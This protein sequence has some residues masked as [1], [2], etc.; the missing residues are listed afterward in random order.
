MQSNQT[1]AEAR[2]INVEPG[3]FLAA[4]HPG[5][6]YLRTFSDTGKGAGRNYQ[7]SAV[8]L[9]ATDFQAGLHLVNQRD[10]QGVFFVVNPGGHRD[11]AITRVAAHFVEADD[12][13]LEEQYANLQTFPLEPSIIVQTRKSLHGYWL[14]QPPESAVADQSQSL[15]SFSSIQKALAAVFKGDPVISNRSRV[16]R[17]PGFFHNK[18]EPVLVTCLKFDP[19]L[20]YTQTDIDLAIQSVTKSAPSPTPAAP[21]AAAKSAS[22]PTA[23][24]IPGFFPSADEVN[25]QRMIKSC[26]FL[27]HAKATAKTLSEPLWYAMITQLA[28]LAGGDAVIQELSRDHPGYSPAATA[29]KIAQFNST[30]AG[31]MTCET[32]RGWGYHCPRLGSCPA[33]S[34]WE[35]GKS[36]L[37]IWYLKKPNGYRLMP[38]ILANE[39]AKHKRI[40]YAGEAYYQYLG[41]VYRMVDD[42]HCQK[43]VR[44]YLRPDHVQMAQINDVLCQWT[45]E[46]SRSAEGLNRDKRIINLKN[47]HYD[48]VTRQLLPHDPAS[49]S[50]IQLQ[51]CYDEKA[52]APIFM[53]FLAD[54]LDE[55][56]QLLIQEIFGYLLIPETCAQKAFVF[57]GEGGAGKSTLLSVAQDV[58]LGP[59]NV[60]NIPWQNLGDRF[61]TAELFGMLGNIF[62]DLPSKSIEDNGLF[63]S[64]TGED[65]ITAER[66][67]KDPFSFKAT[68][69][70]VFSCNSLPKNLGDRS[71]AFYRRLIIVPFLPPKPPEQRDLHLKDKLKGEAAGILNWALAG[72]ARLQANQYR[73]SNS[74]QSDAALEDYRIAGSSVL[75]FVDELC[76]I[77]NQTQVSATELFQAYAHYCQDS[78]LRSVSQKR[79]WMELKEAFPEL[80]KIREL[81]TRRILYAGIELLDFEAAA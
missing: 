14:L 48:L 74:T 26:E 46:I 66:K 53:A 13:P 59:V 41:G 73:F 7:V 3:T 32:L 42:R 10:C 57:V 4:F 51:P 65:F 56:T 18:K 25:P 69:R 55:Q 67:N 47:G 76:V 40:F 62:A 63:K 78:G 45:V 77:K 6:Y 36:P 39:L 75:S 20:R 64:I 23:I 38:G 24:S 71:E 9:A 54:C 19:Q 37:P 15:S 70:L 52:V 12:L 30:G 50:T 17:L 68:A 29:K 34:P 5:P 21:V 35:R 1:L 33:K 58:L 8:E 28:G 79:F 22:S 81:V 2:S 61:K 43:I 80:E 27:I 44:K 49:L 60:S 11:D 31:P 16:M 72:L